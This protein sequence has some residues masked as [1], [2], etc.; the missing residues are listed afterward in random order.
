[1]QTYEELQE[2]IR[3]G[4]RVWLVT[5]AAGFIGSH[6]AENLLRL[7]QTVIGL[8]NFS[9]GRRE[10]VAH[11]DLRLIEGDI[12]SLDTC[13]EACR[14]AD[15]VLHQAALGSVPRSIDKP[16]ATHESNVN[17]FLN[18]LLAAR[19][20]GVGR[21]VYASSSAVYGDDDTMPKVEHK[22][23]K[24]MSPY[25]L[26][27][28]V[29][30]QY[31]GVFAT[32]YGFQSAGLRYFNVFGPR[33][34]PDHPYASVIPA[35]LGALLRGQTAY[36]NGDG[37][38]SRDFCHVDNVVQ[39]NLLAATVED[40]AALNQ[41]YNVAHGE[42]TTLNELFELIRML[43]APRLPHLRTARAVHRAPRRGDLPRSLADIGK[44]VKLL[45]YRPGFNLQSGLRQTVD[46]YAENLTVAHA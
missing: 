19:D 35:W 18:M 30:E 11:L 40:P 15:V 6:L 26:S 34:D 1:M 28:Q 13:R 37:S 33:Q 31:A 32:C 9:T 38:I 39:A 3:A 14:G 4:R 2:R 16:V 45:G 17:G 44:A 46:W 22:T 27:K 25:G 36:I 10:N 24:A 42:Q 20:A 8:D 21:F 23:G 41:A 12:R 29:N 7:G 5:G 43:L